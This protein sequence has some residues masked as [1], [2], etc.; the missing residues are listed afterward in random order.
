MN[1]VIDR[2]LST[3]HG[4]DGSLYINGKYLCDTTEHPRLHLPVG[5]YEVKLKRRKVYGCK[6]PCLFSLNKE[7]NVQAAIFH[8][9]GMAKCRDMR[10]Y[11]GEFR[12]SGL[13]TNGALNYM[14]L[15]ELI[16]SELRSGNCVRLRI[17]N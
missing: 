3:E 6:V 8:G 2:I 11:V 14:T 16:D 17:Q 15:Y 1:I 7:K 13:L 9:N 5:V 12:V 4:V 10:I